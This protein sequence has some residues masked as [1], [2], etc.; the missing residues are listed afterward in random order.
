MTTITLLSMA[1]FTHAHNPPAAV[2]GELVDV[3]DDVIEVN[4]GA[5]VTLCGA[6][7]GR[8]WE[9]DLHS[10]RRVETDPGEQQ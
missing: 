6:E 10:G 5:W 7:T 2:A 8:L 1:Y 9:F 3:Y 4:G